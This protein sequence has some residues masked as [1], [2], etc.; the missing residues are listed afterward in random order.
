[1]TNEQIL[2]QAIEKAKANGWKQTY[3][4]EVINEEPLHFGSDWYNAFIATIF[5]HD[6]AKAFWGEAW[7]QE[8]LEKEA[9]NITIEVNESIERWQHYLQQMVLER[10]PL[11]YLSKFL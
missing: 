9:K 5:S 3:V 2:K 11:E 1:M 10:N 6:F 4:F 7:T 8:E